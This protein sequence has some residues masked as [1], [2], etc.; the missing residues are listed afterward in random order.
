[1]FLQN[2]SLFL[3]HKSGK[4]LLKNE[5]VLLSHTREGENQSKL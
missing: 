4:P 1:M 3:N 5:A 2:S